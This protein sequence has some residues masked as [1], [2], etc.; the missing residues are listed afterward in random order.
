MMTAPAMPSTS[1]KLRELHVAFVW[2]PIPAV[3]RKD[4]HDSR[5]H[6]DEQNCESLGTSLVGRRRKRRWLMIEPDGDID[7]RTAHGQL[8]EGRSRCMAVGS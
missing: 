2:P 5:S 4:S 1:G 8:H 6:H 3:V 7:T